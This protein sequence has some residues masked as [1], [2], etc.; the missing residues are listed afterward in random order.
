MFDEPELHVIKVASDVERLAERDRQRREG[1][2]RYHDRLLAALPL[3]DELPD[4]ASR[5]DA[6]LDNLFI[7]TRR[8]EGDECHCSCHPHLPDNDLHDYGFACACQLTAEER[9]S[10]FAEWQASLDEYWESPAGRAQTAI[11]QAEEDEL[12][13]RLGA[14]PDVVVTTHGGLA[15]E[16]W[17]GSV[18][19]HSFYFRERHG[20]WR[21]ELDLRPSGHFYRAWTGGDLDDDANFEVRETDAGDVIAEGTT[22]AAGYGQTPVERARFIVD[23]IRVHLRRQHCEVHTAV[24]GAD[25]EFCIAR[26]YGW[27]PACG[28]R[29]VAW[30]AGDIRSA[31]EARDLPARM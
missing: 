10:S 15:P 2:Q 12:I 19:G 9:R 8:G 11:R 28:Q 1:R 27:C 21:I 20:D 3:L 26:A 25:L 29:I 6:I 7:V 24:E 5:A 31:G 18:D 16:Q 23:T 17:R 13:A 4:L 14:N 30:P 22:G